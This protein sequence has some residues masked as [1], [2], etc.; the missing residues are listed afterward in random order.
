[1][2]AFAACDKEHKAI[3]RFRLASEWGGGT[4][5]RNNLS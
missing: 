3:E 5:G 1:M 4:D 2:D